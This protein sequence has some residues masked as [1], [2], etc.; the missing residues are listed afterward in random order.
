ME[1]VNKNTSKNIY[2]RDDRFSFLGVFWQTL[3]RL[4]TNFVE[5]IDEL[6]E[7]YCKLNKLF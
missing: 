2:A 4:F 6:I 3:I 1:N 7:K 5:E